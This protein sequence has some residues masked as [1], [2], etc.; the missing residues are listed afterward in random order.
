[1]AAS[2]A[3]AEPSFAPRAVASSAGI[4]LDDLVMS[5]SGAVPHVRISPAPRLGQ[6]L[7][8]SRKQIDEAL[9]AA[10]FSN[11]PGPA[12]IRVGRRVRLLDQEEILQRVAAQL[13]KEIVGSRGE[14]DLRFARP[15]TAAEVPDESLVLKVVDLPPNGLT[16]L[17]V[18]RLELSTSNEIVGRWQV[19]LAAKIWR[20]VW[21]S[22]RPV[23]RSMPLA[24][25]ELGRERRDVLTIHDA[26]A[27]FDSVDDSLET[28]EYL[29]ANT[30]L[31]ARAI[32]PRP[33]I[34]RGQTAAAMLV[35]GGLSISMKVE[36]LEDGIPG[37]LVRIRN[38]QT[39]RE[40]RGK[41]QSEGTI[42]VCL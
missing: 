27:A 33:T 40:L 22:H 19:S 6:M 34:R 29:P 31:L 23:P 26:L 39:R 14:L 17:F 32:K 16:A 2:F 15:W 41:V 8:L 28:S 35:D 30:P 36:V 3:S 37:Q 42:L 5:D 24:N 25:A 7:T 38:P 12:M 18:C 21:V 20:D 10:G 9:S 4:F 1:V 13:Q 11:I